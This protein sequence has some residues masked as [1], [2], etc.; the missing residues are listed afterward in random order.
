MREF[1][2]RLPHQPIFYPV[3]N[4]EYATQIARDWNTKESSFAGYVTKFAV[5]ESYLSKFEPHIVG[6]AKHVLLA[7][8]AISHEITSNMDANTA[9]QNLINLKQ[10]Y[11]AAENAAVQACMDGTGCDQAAATAAQTYLNLINATGDTALNMA[12]FS[13][14]LLGGPPPSSIEDLA[15]EPLFD[16]AVE[17]VKHDAERQKNRCE[18]K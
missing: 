9:A 17:R 7:G 14:T 16:A 3:A 5:V 18:K 2:P 6:S 11:A 4:I 13:G 12:T 15:S 10:N 8:I 1:P